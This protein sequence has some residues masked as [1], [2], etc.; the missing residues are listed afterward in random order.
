[1]EHF[2]RVV[3]EK[4]FKMPE[5]AGKRVMRSKARG[6]ALASAAYQHFNVGSRGTAVRRMLR[7]LLTYPAPLWPPDVRQRFVRIRLLF[8]ILTRHYVRPRDSDAAP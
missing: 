3:L 4:A 8:A 7:S 2:E 6:L 1:M 5:L